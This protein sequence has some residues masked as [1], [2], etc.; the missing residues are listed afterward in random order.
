MTVPL[1]VVVQGVII[2]LTYG[3]LALGLVL[4]YKTSRV[5]NFAHGALGAISAVLLERMVN[6]FHFWYWP[7]FVLTLLVAALIGAGTELLLRR[8]FTRPRFLVMV[9]TIGLA[10]LLFVLSLLSFIQPDE[11][12]RP[13]PVPFT[14]K[15]HIDVFVLQPAH[16][17]IL[18]FAP[19]AALAVALF[20]SLTPYG[21]ALRAAAEN[22][23]SARLGGIWVRRA[24][25]LAWAIAGVL[26]A[27]TAI[28]V[29]P[30]QANVYAQPLGPTLLVRALVAALLGG[31]VNLRVAFLA[32]VGI[33]VLEQIV[34]WNWPE[35]STVE[36]VMFGLLIGA[37]LLR[38]RSLRTT[39][40]TE[41]QSSWQFGAATRMR[42]PAPDRV[43]VSRIGMALALVLALLL[44]A[45]ISNSR[46]FV[47]T[48]I[49]VFAIVGVSLTILS[50]WSGQLSLGHFGF[51]AVGAIVTARFGDDLPLPLLLV[52]AGTVAAAVAIV[53]GLPAL[54]IRGLY[55]AVTTLGFA[56]LVTGWL[57]PHQQLGLPDPAS[58]RVGRP[59]LFGFD[60]TS[61]KR[62]YYFALGLMLLVALGA[63]NLRRSGIGR[64]MIAVRD[65]ETA[66]GAM[67]IRVMRT[68]LTAFAVSGFLAGVGGVAFA[69]GLFRFNVESFG[70]ERSIFVVSIAVIGGMGSIAG[71]LLGALYLIGLPAALGYSIAVDFLVAGVGL[72][73]FILYLPGGLVSVVDALGDSV[74]ALWRRRAA[75][76]VASA[77]PTEVAP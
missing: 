46:S 19:I 23:D 65:N 76:P 25:T 72:T 42:I 66:A 47:F 43:L 69:Y 50:G 39:S 12:A 44:P 54:R 48:Q 53:V 20:F 24:S 56:V 27:V 1:H 30:F 73:I 77:A 52:V 61:E 32:G 63:H 2:G 8:L 70:A 22:A 55:L 15:A 41:E 67:G 7:T 14:L 16:F 51:V 26:S 75:T 13:F 29:G 33:G 58:Q 35:P 10:Q 4:I 49:F 60:L 68:K 36:A 17:V 18:F 45:V 74:T 37:L 31:M 9:A 5:L 71:A 64:S 62:Y 59:N 11:G 34:F 40:R 6:D 21:L 38:V 3:L 28:L 57:L